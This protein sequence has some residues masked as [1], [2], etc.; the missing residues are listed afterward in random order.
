[1]RKGF[2]HLP[3]GPFED[4]WREADNHG[5]M[6]GPAKLVFKGI[7]I[8]DACTIGNNHLIRITLRMRHIIYYDLLQYK[9]Y[10]LVMLFVEAN[11]SIRF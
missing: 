10:N 2:V 1:M 5:Y 6:I 3:R 9:C 8:V 11:G 4:E 7:D